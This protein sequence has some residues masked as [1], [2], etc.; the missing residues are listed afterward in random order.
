VQPGHRS[1]QCPRR[2]IV[3]FIKPDL[4]TEGVED[5]LAYTYE[6]DEVT[7][8]DEGELLSRSLVV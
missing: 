2:S 4:T 8:G 5:E 6:E 3:N 1:N 7:W